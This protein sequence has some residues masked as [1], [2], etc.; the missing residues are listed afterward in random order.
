MLEMHNRFG[1]DEVELFVE[2]TPIDLQMNS[3]IRNCTPLL[4]G[5]ND[6]TN[7]VQNPFTL[8]HR[9]EEDE[10]DEEGTQCDDDSVG[11]ED[12]HNDDNQDGEG[13]MSF[14]VICEA[15]K[16]EQ[17][18]YVVV[19]GGGCNLSN[20]PNLEDLDDPIDYLQCNIIWHHHH[21]L[22]MLKTLVMLCQVN[23]PH[24]ETLLWDIQL[25]SS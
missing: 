4:L 1:M 13:C 20:N 11:A 14:L 18:R 22:K 15:I 16:R 19:D 7:N 8:E 23:G 12:V 25:E 10:E 24:G 3:P 9:S 2:Q 6:G 5:E 21:S 17:M